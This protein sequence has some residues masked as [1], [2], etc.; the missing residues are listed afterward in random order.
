MIF[1][2]FIPCLPLRDYVEAFHIRHFT[3]PQGS[4]IPF[5][6]YHGQPEQWLSFYIRDSET[7]EYVSENKKIIRPR[8]VISGQLPYA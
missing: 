7:L 8:S 2:S 5:K 3:Y 6:P 4:V 1:E